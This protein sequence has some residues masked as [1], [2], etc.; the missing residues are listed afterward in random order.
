[1]LLTNIQT[2]TT[3][4][5][6]GSYFTGKVFCLNLKKH[7]KFHKLMHNPVQNT[8][9]VMQEHLSGQVVC[10]MVLDRLLV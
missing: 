6:V 3:R 10:L 4:Q 7:S 9:S 2:N 1:M 5:Y 8:C